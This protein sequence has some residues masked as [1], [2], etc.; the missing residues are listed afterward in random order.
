MV[1]ALA[2][3]CL[4]V[5]DLETSEAFYCGSLGLKPA[6]EF[7]NDR[8]ERFGLY[9]HLGGRSFL[10]LFR[11]EPRPV[12][13]ASFAHFCLEADDL[14]ATVAALRERGLE[15]TTPALGSDG[16]WQAWLADPDGNRIE[17]HMYTP[18]SKQAPHLR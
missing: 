12:E 15:I 11:G 14:E 1:T 5:R 8:G 4:V 7:R 10:E 2:H 16:S 9:L 18:E 3:L 6:F 13:N 17:L